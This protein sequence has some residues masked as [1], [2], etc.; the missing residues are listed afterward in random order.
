[1]SQF[2]VLVAAARNS[3]KVAADSDNTPSVR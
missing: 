2:D 3:K 1:M